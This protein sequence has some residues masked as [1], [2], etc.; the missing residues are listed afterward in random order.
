MDGGKEFSDQNVIGLCHIKDILLYPK[1]ILCIGK[2][3]TP[4]EGI[5]ISISTLLITS[6]IFIVTRLMF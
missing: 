2:T 3:I 6:F 4:Y 1:E 5:L